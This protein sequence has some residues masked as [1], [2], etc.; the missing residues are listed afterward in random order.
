MVQRL[1]L[2]ALVIL[3]IAVLAKYFIV[4]IYNGL[5]MTEKDIKD[6]IEKTDK[7]LKK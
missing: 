6:G 3:I 7:K 5:R 4:P 1:I 2:A